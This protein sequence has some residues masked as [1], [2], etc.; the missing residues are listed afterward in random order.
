MS[1]SADA[2]FPERFVP[3]EMHGLIEAEHVARYRWASSCV[4]GLRVL[5][6]GCGT[7]YGSRLLGAAGAASVTGVDIAEEAIEAARADGAEGVQFLRGD[8]SDLPFEDASFD[9]VVC[10]EAIEHVHDQ[11]RTLD[12]LHRLLNSTGLLIVSSPNR[13]VYQEGN[14][15]HTHEFAPEELRGALEQRFANVRLERQQAWLLSMVCDDATLLESDPGHTLDLE[16]RKV[17][18][19]KPG[20]E[21]FTLALAGK[22]ELPVP[23]DLAI[24]TNLGELDAWR[25]RS[26]SAEEHL[27]RARRDTADA[28]AAYESAQAN[29]L[30]A[31]ANY[32]NALFALEA[33]QRGHE[34][35]E[36]SL[37]RVSMLLAERNAALRIATEEL[38][39]L[40]GRAA[41]LS[42]E[43][44][45]SNSAL[46]RL[47]GS[48]S[49]RMTA[50]LR[51]LGR[52]WRTLR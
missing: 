50:P 25:S 5:D 19:I 33:S 13:E 22:A 37:Q 42:A 30:A 27:E 6:A 8:I 15:H 14:P 49:W 44:F 17:A 2:L 41:A 32:E 45:A 7:G 16:V 21:T 40:Q 10:F 52:A 1:D 29:Y 18:G 4:S 3:G 51:A 35:S 38:E 48:R 23:P 11:A 12:E 26:R 34:R 36:R 47:A 39:A 9:V 24:L 43:L 20:S 31:Q 46:A 28:K